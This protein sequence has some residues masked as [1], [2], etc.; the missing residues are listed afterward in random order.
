LNLLIESS[1]PSVQNKVLN[2]FTKIEE[3]KRQQKADAVRAIKNH[4]S[5]EVFLDCPQA[6]T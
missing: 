3:Q 2:E 6:S 1:S 4:N 5:A